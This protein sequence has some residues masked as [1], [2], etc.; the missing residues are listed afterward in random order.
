MT[1]SQP[2]LARSEYTARRLGSPVSVAGMAIPTGEDLDERALGE[3]HLGALAQRHSSLTVGDLESVELGPSRV[4]MR[5]ARFSDADAGHLI[6]VYRTV[7]GTLEA[8]VAEG[9][10]AEPASVLSRAV[11]EWIE[12]EGTVELTV[13]EFRAIERLRSVAPAAVIPR[14]R[15]IES[16]DGAAGGLIDTIARSL[17]L[18]GILQRQRE[19]GWAL[20][21]GPGAIVEPL[22]GSRHIAWVTWAD[23]AGAHGSAA[24][25]RATT[26]WSL[27]RIDHEV[28]RATA[29]DA[30]SPA[31]AA[32]ALG[33][34]SA[35]SVGGDGAPIG[36]PAAAVRP[37]GVIEGL[38]TVVA[39]CAARF[40]RAADD[41][42]EFTELCWLHDDRSGLWQ[43]SA[44][45]AASY[46]AAPVDGETLIARIEEGFES[47]GGR[48]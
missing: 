4:L 35:N 9:P 8:L 38:G 21:A 13:E 32:A 28:L 12:H 36:A 46:S 47:K 31:A 24:I 19:D 18:R 16:D 34:V 41:G 10:A 15:A 39:A 1:E 11:L 17:A 33:G 29:L 48:P 23:A 26:A 43:V 5:Y 7:R 3:W 30:V 14:A 27:L 2:W 40:I 22:V 6:A 42:L 45:P 37:G 20:T 44:G 25:G